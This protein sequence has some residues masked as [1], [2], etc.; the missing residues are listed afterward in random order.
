MKIIENS[1]SCMYACNTT[2]D[3]IAVLQPNG[4]YGYVDS[5]EWIN[6]KY[7]ATWQFSVRE[8][9]HRCRV[10]IAE[11]IWVRP[12]DPGEKPQI[13]T[14]D[15][16]I[17]PLT[18]EWWRDDIPTV[19]VDFDSPTPGNSWTKNMT[20]QECLKRIANYN[21]GGSEGLDAV[22]KFMTKYNLVIKTYL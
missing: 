16:Y 21:D 9:T 8:E 13:Y 20:L 19:K 15:H 7:I 18:S 12:C 14:F 1:N 22:V 2:K 5:I 4:E 6:G 11:G 3:K 17:T 10:Y